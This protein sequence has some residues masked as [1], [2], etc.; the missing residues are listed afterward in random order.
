MVRLTGRQASNYQGVQA[1]SPPNFVVHPRVP[2][3]TDWQNFYLGDLW[4]V[5]NTTLPQ[6]QFVY[7]LVSLRNNIARWIRFAGGNGNLT[8][9][10]S[11]SGGTVFGDALQNINT[12]GD[13]T[14]ITGIGDP[15]TNT[16]TFSV[17]G[18]MAA[19]SFVASNVTTPT[20]LGGIAA[21]ITGVINVQA[22]HN[23]NASAGLPNTGA[24]NDIVYWT[25]NASTWG[26]LANITAGNSAVNAFT[27]D[28][29]ITAN[30]SV[31]NLN[32]PNT[33]SGGNAG[34]VTYGGTGYANR[35]VSNFGTNNTFI[36]RISGNN[37]LT[38]ASAVSN[39]G[40]GLS[41]LAGLTT[42]A[43]NS[44]LG[45]QAG[46]LITTGSGNSF[47]GIAS[48]LFATTGSFNTGVGYIA[49]N[50]LTNGVTTGSFNTAL[51]YIA[52]FNYTSS[53]SSNILISNS[54][55]VGESHIVRIGTTGS[56]NG[57]Q[58]K[59]FVSSV[60]GITTD[61]ADGI[62]VLVSSTN[63]LGTG[64]GY[65]ASGTWTPV[66]TFGGGSTGITYT[67]QAG[68]YNKIGNLVFI[69]ATLFF[70]KGSSTGAIIISGL[71]YTCTATVNPEYDL[72]VTLG[73]GIT[74]AAGFTYFHANVIDGTTT[75]QMYQDNTAGGISNQMD[76]TYFSAS[77][78]FTLSGFYSIV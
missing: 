41:S 34:I 48:G 35:F 59:F 61:A 58:N 9:L 12:V 28:I 10:T 74:A 6:D 78:N 67:I 2:T 66:V 7:I 64:D 76:N 8:S 27:G 68:S 37:T 23:L 72:A 50:N 51:G 65:F 57:Q 53:E 5:N 45:V 75:I 13:G 21:P 69:A 24:A 60:R 40:I 39:V 54:G 14:T 44:C 30:N 19:N 22:N 15:A 56:G 20:G 4:E 38:T 77:V 18:G 52:G 32:L 73:R 55:V 36:G 43:N 1:S 17:I 11:N 71:P 46:N 47:I 25:T 3:P 49:L 16:I 29:T 33:T 26:D 63:Q 70:A 42:G 31:G 62:P